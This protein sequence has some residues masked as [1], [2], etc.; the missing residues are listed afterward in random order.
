MAKVGT[1]SQQGGGG[2]LYK[3]YIDKHS[4]AWWWKRLF[5]LT[6]L[7]WMQKEENYDITNLRDPESSLSQLLRFLLQESAVMKLLLV[8]PQPFQ[9]G[10]LQVWSVRN[11]STMFLSWLVFNN[12]PALMGSRPWAL[13][14]GCTRTWGSSGPPCRWWSTTWRCSKTVQLIIS[15]SLGM[16]RHFLMVRKVLSSLMISVLCAICCAASGLSMASGTDH[17]LLEF[18]N[19]SLQFS[20]EFSQQFQP[21]MKKA[22]H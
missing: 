5:T 8:F 12:C 18:A 7:Q 2:W 9:F 4:R 10:S 6:S 11:L 1:L 17:R 21:W 14:R 3:Q 22:C 20:S 13:R 15:F 16:F 19:D